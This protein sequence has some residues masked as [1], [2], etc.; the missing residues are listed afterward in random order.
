M[1]ICNCFFGSIIINQLRGLLKQHNEHEVGI[2][3]ILHIV[4]SVIMAFSTYIVI[5]GHHQ[6][7]TWLGLKR[8][9]WEWIRNLLFETQ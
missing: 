8:F 7:S 3:S 6:L 5:R 9:F 4:I 2:L 1:M